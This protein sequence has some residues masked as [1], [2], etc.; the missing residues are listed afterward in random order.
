MV[1]YVVIKIGYYIY[2]QKIRKENSYV[3]MTPHIVFSVDKRV[4]K[5]VK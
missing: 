1:T 3:T 5:S 2:N 4:I